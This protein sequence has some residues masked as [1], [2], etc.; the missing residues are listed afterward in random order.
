MHEVCIFQGPE[1]N[2][3]KC[4]AA[5]SSS[6]LNAAASFLHIQLM[7]LAGCCWLLLSAANEVIG[8]PAKFPFCPMSSL[9]RPVSSLDIQ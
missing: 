4:V 2:I 7:L 6:R 9:D 8:H 1:L 5:A 3:Q